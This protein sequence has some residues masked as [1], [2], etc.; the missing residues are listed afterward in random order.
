MGMS[1]RA[2]WGKIKATEAAIGIRLVKRN[3]G[4]RSGYNLTEE[5]R[6]LMIQYKSWLSRVEDA[7]LLLAH[8]IFPFTAKKFEEPCESSSVNRVI[9]QTSSVPHL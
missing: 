7:A 6:R 3:A 5:G 4:K 9:P 2:A 8:D 1:Y